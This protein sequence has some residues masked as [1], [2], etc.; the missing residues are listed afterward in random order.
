M[1]KSPT[2]LRMP[3]STL[4]VIGDNIAITI[5]RSFLSPGLDRLILNRHRAQFLS[6][7]H[8]NIAE[9][10]LLGDGEFLR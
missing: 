8:E 4:M 5:I 2:Q 10:V 7:E 3:C 9:A 1:S 6:Y